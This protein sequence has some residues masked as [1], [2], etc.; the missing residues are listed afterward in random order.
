M[1]WTGRASA[2]VVMMLVMLQ[3]TALA[4]RQQPPSDART[5]DSGVREAKR[6]IESGDA[7]RAVALL[8]A[9]QRGGDPAED[10]RASLLLGVAYYGAGQPA[11]AVETLAPIADRFAPGSPERREADRVLGLAAFVTG[12]FADAVPRLE[13]TARWATGN[14]ELSYALAQAYV[15]TQQ[16]DAARRVLAELYGVPRESAAARV[17]AAQIMIRLEMNDLA[18]AELHAALAADPRTPH[19]NFLL[20]Q[21]ALFRGRLDE[22]VSRSTQELQVDP[23]SAIA[24]SQLGDAYVRQAK[25]NDA[26]AALQKSIWLNPYYSAPYILLGRAYMKTDQ[27]SIAEGMLRRAIEYDPNNRAAHYLLGQ[28]LQQS[29]RTEDAQREFD[30]AERLPG[31]RGG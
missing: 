9:R 12:R 13:A 7:A 31:T 1:T 28:L 19:A 16:P 15:R 4:A 23:S 30:I 25:W 5:S 10:L 22:A 6:L 17:I 24:F 14:R 26:I 20:G 27:P 2:R 18:E 21:L 3:A 11:R 8:E 29:G